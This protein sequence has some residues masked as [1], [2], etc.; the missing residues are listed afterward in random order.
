MS[1]VTKERTTSA[2]VQSPV[3]ELPLVV[4]CVSTLAH[5]GVWV[6]HEPEEVLDVWG[7]TRDGHPRDDRQDVPSVRGRTCCH[8]QVGNLNV[9][10][11]RGG[12]V[13]SPR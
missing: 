8:A 12:G 2:V 6:S 10:L 9:R 5:S 4:P 13:A 3:R 1:D 11:K 7:R